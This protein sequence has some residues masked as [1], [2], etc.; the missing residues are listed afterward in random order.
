MTSLLN[1]I[2]LHLKNATASDPLSIS[3]GL[4]N[5][6]SIERKFG[7]IAAVQASTPADVWEYGVTPGAEIYTFSDNGVADIDTISSS[8][9]SD[10]VAITIEGLDVNGTLVSQN[11][12][13]DGQ[14]KVTLSTPLWRVN[15]AFNSNSTDLVGNVYIYV[16]GAISSG[17]PD[18]VTTV[19]GYISAGNGQT[20]QSVY[21][22][23][24]GKTAY[25][26]GIEASLTK[27]VGATAVSALFQGSTRAY[28][29]IFRIQDEFN[30]IS[31][32]TSSKTYN[33]PLPLPFSERT[34]FCPRVNV[35]ANNLGVS[36][37]FSLILI[38]N[39]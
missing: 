22:V 25:F 1:A 17:V 30:L 11:A 27:G 31:T 7:S 15:R 29:K 26:V 4:V 19:R 37:A 38:D 36:W 39:E 8:N 13:L 32:G 2:R 5:G 24:A 20:L 3:Q 12:T 21:T 10:S 14:N 33:L 16:D 34:D 23:P 35:S 9:S 18:V 28:G 6:R